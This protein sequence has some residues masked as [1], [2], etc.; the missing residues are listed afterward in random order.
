MAFSGTVITSVIIPDNGVQIGEDA[1]EDCSKLEK[2][3]IPASATL[4]GAI[5]DDRCSNLKTA[6]PIGDDYNY[7]FDWTQEIPAYAFSGGCLETI[8]LPNTITTIGKDAFFECKSLKSIDLPSKLQEIQERAFCWCTSLE[9][10]DIPDGVQKIGNYAFSACTTLHQVTLPDSLETLG[11]GAF[12]NCFRL[13]SIVIPN[14]VER[15]GSRGFFN[16]PLLTS[17]YFYGNAPQVCAADE[18]SHSFDADTAVL[19]YLNG[20]TGWSTPTWNG[21]QT[22]VWAGGPYPE[23]PPVTP[24]SSNETMLKG[25]KPVNGATNVGYDAADLPEFH[26]QFNKV[27]A[28]MN[29]AGVQIDASKEPFAIY[30][31][32]DDTLIWED[33]SARLNNK[34]S[35]KMVV[36][37][38]RTIVTVTPTNAHALLEKNTA[39]YITMGEGYIKFEDG[40]TSPAIQ[41]GDWSFRTKNPDASITTDITM[42]TGV[43]KKTGD[44][45]SDINAVVRVTWKDS[46]FDNSSY[47]YMH[48]LATAAMALSGAAYVK[49]GERPADEKIQEAFTALGF[50]QDTIQSYNYDVEREKLNNDMVS[51]SFAAKPVEDNGTAYTLVAIV[52]KGTSGDEEWYSN[53]HVGLGNQ[54][55]G[56]QICTADVMKNLNQYLSDQ[57]LE[58]K[59]LKFLVTGHSRCAAVANLT[60][61]ELTNSGLTQAR[62]VYGYTFATPAV[63]V[64]N[65]AA[66]YNNIFNIINGEDFVPRLPLA[67]W[68][69]KRYGVDLLLPSKSYYGSGYNQVYNAMNTEYYK[70]T[71]KAYEP[72]NDGT[73]KVDDLVKNVSSFAPTVKQYYENKNAAG[74][75]PYQYFYSLAY[76]IVTGEVGPLL[77]ASVGEYA[78]VTAFFAEN[79]TLNSRVFSAHSMAAYYSWMD[80]CT[81][82]E[83]FGN[84]NKR[85]EAW[86]KRAVI[87]CPV[88]VYVYDEAGALVASVV[89][90]TIG[91]NLL[92]VNVEDGVK[93]ID[94]PNDQNY[95]IRI[96][97]TDDGSVTYTVDEYQATSDGGEVLR[98]VRMNN[99]AITQGDQL[100]GKV[101]DTMDT[102]SRNYALTKNEGT[103]KE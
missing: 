40:S 84:P 4:L 30:R 60:A 2:L 36:N 13:T 47:Y 52:I 62:N 33:P 70:L 74:L 28:T 82:E 101:D 21:Y 65:N 6:G 66:N 11:D 51:Y 8:V 16:C 90:E 50:D 71:E 3:V 91:A 92:A 49:H 103:A 31:A 43:K 94:M 100:T 86:F 9:T 39:Y 79:H 72:Y 15:I 25:T 34:F 59:N 80:S 97:A 19:Y 76:S 29:G 18:D 68:N 41:K 54:H 1:F 12:A 45:K 69:Y 67:K 81:A 57:D 98:T 83:L 5:L 58:D 44:T 32:S 99:I 35:T 56:F 78:P 96:V 61:K 22:E 53:F 87:A 20:K 88:D 24:P 14:G 73:Q 26:M 48:D 55:A 38:D 23:Q 10:L 46:W 37:T 27:P 95:D 102:T 17:I 89:N 77:V 85:T 7:E 42:A 63:A 93:T 64:D 75:T